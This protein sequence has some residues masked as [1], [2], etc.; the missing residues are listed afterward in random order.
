MNVVVT[1]SARETFTPREIAAAYEQFE[2][3]GPQHLDAETGI[4]AAAYR[5][6]VRVLLAYYEAKTSVV[7]LTHPSALRDCPKRVGRACGV[8]LRTTVTV[9]FGPTWPPYTSQS[10]ALSVA[11]TPFRTVS[12]R[13]AIARDC[14]GVPMV[15][16]APYPTRW[17]TGR[18]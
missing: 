14:P 1:P 11:S 17:D 6:G 3:I 7:V 18:A 15:Q 10:H 12:P 5:F 13:T 9:L 16:E 4:K 2:V 8:A